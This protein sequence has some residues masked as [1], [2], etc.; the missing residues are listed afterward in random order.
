MTLPVKIAAPVAAGIL[1]ASLVPGPYGTVNRFGPRGSCF[2][3]STQLDPVAV[4]TLWGP[5]KTAIRT[6]RNGHGTAGSRQYPGCCG[7]TS[8]TH[9]S[10]STS[11]CGLSTE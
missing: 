1:V 2:L 10:S 8:A 4:S 9:A 5:V 3:Q 6:K 7:R 11:P